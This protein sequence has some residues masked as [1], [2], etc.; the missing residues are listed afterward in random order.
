[1]SNFEQTASLLKTLMSSLMS[2]DNDERTKAEGALNTEWV[3]TQPQ[4]VLGSLAYLVHRDSEPKARAFAAIL[5]RRISFQNAAA[6]EN[7]EDQH[8]VWSVVPESVHQTVKAELLGALQRETD[9]SA[10]HKL[11]DTISEIVDHE[12][13]DGWAELLGALY[14]CA[15]DGNALLRESAY[16][17]FTSCPEL[18]YQQSMAAVSGA[19]TG[20]FQD[21]D[22]D[23]RLAALQ[24]AVAF[25]VNAEEKQKTA[26]TPM[27]GPMLAVLEPLVQ[28]G[29]EAGLV[30]ALLALMEAA[31]E[32][33][34]MFRGVLD[35]LIPFATTI[36]KNSDME[37][38]TQ[39]SA[40]EL[41]VTLAEVAPGMCRKNAQFCQQLVPVCMQMMSS[42]E[43][44]EDWHNSDS[45]ED[46]DNDE[47]WVFGEQ[48][49]DRLAI[50]LGGKQV[51][52]IAFKYIPDM[53]A[54]GEWAQR[55]A[56]LSAISAIGE[57]C[58][59]IMRGELTQ[60]LALIA[61][62]FEDAHPRVRYAA[63]NCYGQMSTDFAPTIQEKHSAVVLPRLMAAMGDSHSRVQ[64]HAAAAMVNFAEEA[65]KATL[66]PFLDTLLERLLS[67]L[68]SAKRYVQEQAITTIATLAEN[69]QSRFVKY[70]GTIMPMLLN[71]LA[72]ATDVEHRML[73]GKAMECATF[74][75][76]AVGRDVFAADSARL[77][78]LL[79]AAQH[80]VT[81]ADDPQASYLQQ[82]WARLC[83]LLGAE[84]VPIL[85][86]VMPPLIT[87][88]AQQPDFA[89]L[90]AEEDAEASYSAEDGWE[91]TSIGGQQIGIR[92]SALEEKLDAVELIGSY[93]S[94]LGAGFL[95]YAAQALEIIVP[96]FR[97]Y[98]H[99]GVR[100]VA[101]AAVPQIL[102]TV[103]AAGDEAALRQ[104]WSAI[105]DKYLS[106]LDGEEDDTFAM[107]LFSSFADAVGIVGDG[108]MTEAQLQAFTKACVGQMSKYYQ[109]M[110]DR[111][112][113]RA[114]Q[115]LDEDDEEQL[116]EEELIEGQTVDE[117]AKSLHAV[118]KTHGP[119]YVPLFQNMLPLA[120]KYLQERD[121]AARQW[122]I[123]VFDDLVEFAGPAS[124]Q[125][126]G[127]F[128]DA[129][130]V[131]LRQTESPD[132]RQAAAY[133]VGIMA[134]SGGDA[135]ADF[136]IATAL[137]AMLEMIG[138]PD[139]RETENIFATENMVS[140]VAKVLRVYVSRLG[141][142]AQAV[143]QAWFAAL[144]VCNDDEEVPGVYE[145][146]VQMLRENPEALLAGNDPRAV[147][148]LVK[149]VV[150]ALAVCTLPQELA[151]ALV[152]VMQG[153]L[154]SF[155]DAAKAALWAEIPR[156]Q[157][158]ALQDKGLI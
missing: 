95:P 89:I 140:A 122:A 107:A 100:A 32:A 147:K 20:A 141:G 124:A 28:S 41:L 129:I 45:L 60:I 110:K 19:F 135:Y 58:Y 69:A 67:M 73:R 24:A 71:V 154:A 65:S 149:V 46:G 77:V 118:L 155:D 72:Q 156:E 99:D 82:A 130:A 84:F 47:S 86:V 152:G 158:Q 63:C 111:E 54:S 40:V 35:S 26:L 37:S 146:L 34:K 16:R 3:A 9:R 29:D 139:A 11:C 33:P 127:D 143:L 53:M 1:M 27:I 62:M 39:Q 115:E 56:A 145:Y 78:E 93:A 126:A 44:D 68:S 150:E 7:K 157:Q 51:L 76:L 80:A 22:A 70:Y 153:T 134:K 8:T 36:A 128:L 49:M 113:A 104:V 116:L 4:T 31:Q 48:T 121:P 138:R 114:A 133:G 91:F 81:D 136:V 23:V 18:L 125:F 55:T 119:A 94:D 88:A 120:R 38:R 131:A 90:D 85:P 151:Q 57:G 66:E 15:Q 43:D 74:I 14:A 6:A 148:H 5:L 109:R 50:A 30:D 108:C 103:R 2:S 42:I 75:A 59:K 64:A 137:P 132:L 97:F 17:I 98:Y 101:A 144:P 13:Q 96:L 117:V 106:V 10:R 102:A 123:C 87:A 142:D 52:P 21:A 61:P 25:I 112:A 12:G 105:C 92:T 79:T 83:K